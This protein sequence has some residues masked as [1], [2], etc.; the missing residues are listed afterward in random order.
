MTGLKNKKQILKTLKGARG[1]ERSEF[2]RNG[3]TLTDW[4]GGPHLV[5]GNKKK[6]NNKR[7]CRGKVQL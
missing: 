4:M 3:G 7:A 2:F 6:K 1:I 5:V